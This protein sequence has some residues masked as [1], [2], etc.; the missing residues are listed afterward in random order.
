MADDT[1]KPAVVGQ[2]EPSVRPCPFCGSANGTDLMS[3]TYRWRLWQCNDCG[4]KGPEV[5]CNISGAGRGGDAEARQLALE[6]WN[7][8]DDAALTQAR[9]DG[10]AAAK[11]RI[12]DWLQGQGQPGYAHEVHYLRGFGEA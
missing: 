5:R 10:I 7:E 8:R 9:Q 3:E 2:V 1:N 11:R 4:A 12:A 6:A